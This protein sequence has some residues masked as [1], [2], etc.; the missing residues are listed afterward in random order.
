MTDTQPKALKWLIRCISLLIASALAI[1]SE[2]LHQLQSIEFFFAGAAL[3]IV[4]LS[5]AASALFFWR[6]SCIS[7]T[8]SIRHRQSA[9][10]I[11][12]ILGFITTLIA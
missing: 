11:S 5:I 8:P 9:S 4:S 6:I 12:A 7:L 2:G 10:L 1:I 3:S